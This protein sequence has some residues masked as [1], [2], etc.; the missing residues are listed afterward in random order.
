MAIN[1]PSADIGR[2]IVATTANAVQ[3]SLTVPFPLLAF[4]IIHG[5]D[6]FISHTFTPFPH[7]LY[8][9]YRL[10]LTVTDTAAA[11]QVG[12][13]ATLATHTPAA[14]L[15]ERI[16]D[17]M[18]QHPS[19]G[20]VEVL[21]EEVTND[22]GSRNYV[23]ALDDY[24]Y[25]DAHLTFLPP[26]YFHMWFVKEVKDKIFKNQQRG[27]YR[28]TGAVRFKLQSQHPQA[29]THMLRM[30]ATPLIPMWLHG[31]P[32]EVPSDASTP[33]ERDTYAAFVLGSFASDRVWRT[34]P[35]EP[36]SVWLQY[37]SW[38]A[39]TTCPFH[40]C[41]QQVLKNLQAYFSTRRAQRQR[42][43]VRAAALKAAQDLA[44]ELADAGIVAPPH[45]LPDD[46]SDDGDMQVMNATACLLDIK[47]SLH[48]P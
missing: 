6:N 35:G 45:P 20:E 41:T 16:D 48:M 25:R 47:L 22:S 4:Y 21:H 10:A 43:E 7:F 9:K 29:S 14:A 32:N 12:T 39:D 37:R 1:Q 30:R 11:G 33:S 36:G 23:S 44:Q 8:S 38:L 5:S 15:L 31:L 13:A 24:I 26:F 42:S 19:T 40:S 3:G 28:G 18:E 17:V 34:T 46:L 27:E 2:S